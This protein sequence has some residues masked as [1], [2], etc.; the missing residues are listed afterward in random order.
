MAEQHDGLLEAHRIELAAQLQQRARGPAHEF[1]RHVGD[2]IIGAHLGLHVERAAGEALRHAHL[3]VGILLPSDRQQRITVGSLTR[4]CRAT[5]ATERLS[6]SCGRS[7]TS[8]STR[9]SA[10][11]KRPRAAVRKRNQPP[12]APLAGALRSTAAHCAFPLGASAHQYTSTGTALCRRIA[13]IGMSPARILPRRP[14][15]TRAT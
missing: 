14:F 6:I 1:G 15:G 11:G 12:A 7:I 5:A 9:R 4:A 8:S 2:G 13:R 10:A 3:E